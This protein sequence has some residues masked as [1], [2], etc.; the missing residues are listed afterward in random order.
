MSFCVTIRRDFA[1]AG[2]FG[3]ND[4]PRYGYLIM[5]IAKKS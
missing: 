4:Y 2:F 3:T 1:A 5:S